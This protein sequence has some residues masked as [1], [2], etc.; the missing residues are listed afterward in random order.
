MSYLRNGYGG[1]FKVRAV[2]SPVETFDWLEDHPMTR[3]FL[4]GGLGNQ[5]FQFAAGMYLENRGFKVSF[6]TSLID[7]PP[8]GTTQRTVGIGDLIYGSTR[9]MRVPK[10]NELWLPICSRLKLAVNETS[11]PEWE[12]L[13]TRRTLPG[14]VKGYFQDPHLVALVWEKLVDKFSQHARWNSLLSEPN[15][16]RICVHIRRG[17]YKNLDGHGVLSAS[18]YERCLRAI[19]ELDSL[20][21]KI[22]VISDEPDEA[23]EMLRALEVSKGFELA[24][25]E[26]ASEWSDFSTLC[27]SR[28]VIAANSSFSWWGATIAASKGAEVFGPSPWFRS[29]TSALDSS[30]WKFISSGFSG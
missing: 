15:K 11:G 19:R 2:G 24:E 3:I 17:D 23:L 21:T 25:G 10:Y 28:I 27:S 4:Q 6:A 1:S 13:R 5:L 14:G 7:S 20:D 18:Y 22:V 8:Q 26:T 16:N 29:E 9:E 30:P 12:S